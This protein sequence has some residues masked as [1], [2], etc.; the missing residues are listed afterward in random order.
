MKAVRL[1]GIRDLRVEE[2]PEPRPSPGEV[3]VQVEAVGVCASDLHYYLHGS[4]GGLDAP[5]GLILGHEFS[6]VVAEIGPAAD[7][8]LRIGQRVAVEP[9]RPCNDCRE[10]ARGDYH[11]CRTLRFFGTPPT[12]GALC[13]RVICPVE[14]AFPLPEG[15]T[16]VEGA[17]ME[18]LAVGVYAAELAGLQGGET[19]V[20]VGCGAI[21]LSTLQALK[22]SGAARVHAEDLLPERT[23]L[24]V[25]LGAEE[26]PCPSHEAY[27]AAECAGTPE[28]LARALELVRP[29]GTVL[30]AGIPDEDTLTLPASVVRRKGLTLR[31]VRR[32]RH[33]FPRA[34]RW[35]AEGKIQ[36]APFL[37]HRFALEETAAAFDLAASRSDG[38]IRAWV[39]LT[40]RD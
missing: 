11:L 38:V 30:V 17:M 1:R 14:W 13:E 5:E 18:P 2:I 35:T 32:Y 27:V 8:P 31:F 4:I 20:V 7:S 3:A 10:C 9:V 40:G 25:R 39:D 12:N 26:E 22:A 6:G 28:G 34:I 37:T 23:A 24:A 36:V 21:G 19:A 29:G 16:A 33:C 15:M